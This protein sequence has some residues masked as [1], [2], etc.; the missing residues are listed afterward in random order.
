MVLAW[1]AG[2]AIIRVWVVTVHMVDMDRLCGSCGLE[3][4]TGAI[5]FDRA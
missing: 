4:P 3:R 5:G 1:R 2:A